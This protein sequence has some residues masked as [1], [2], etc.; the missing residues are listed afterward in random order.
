MQAK[1]LEPWYATIDPDPETLAKARADFGGMI[2]TPGDHRGQPATLA[3]TNRHSRDAPSDLAG[4][5]SESAETRW[6]AA[7]SGLC[8][9]AGNDHF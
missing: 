4:A 2:L 8:R 5:A 1:D 7:W 3:L 6:S 9:C